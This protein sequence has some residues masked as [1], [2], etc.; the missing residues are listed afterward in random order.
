[1]PSFEVDFEAYCGICGEGACSD[2]KVDYTS[3]RRHLF[4]SVSCKTCA[5]KIE[6]LEAELD[7]LESEKE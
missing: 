7:Q 1:M 6:D 3:G 2:T 5:Q 4:V